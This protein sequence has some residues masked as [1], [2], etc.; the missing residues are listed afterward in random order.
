MQ[1]PGQRSVLRSSIAL[2]ELNARIAFAAG[3]AATGRAAVEQLLVAEEER[4]TEGAAPVIL[5]A[6]AS[7]GDARL[8]DWCELAEAAMSSLRELAPADAEERSLR[9]LRIADRL[10]GIRRRRCF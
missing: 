1:E 8:G 4:V 10:D 6:E 9:L 3:D 2:H 7:L 5:A